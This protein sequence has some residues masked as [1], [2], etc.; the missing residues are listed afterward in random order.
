MSK[1]KINTII[2]LILNLFVVIS[3]IIIVALYFTPNSGEGNMN[4]SG[5]EC[6]KFFTIDSNILV[7]ITCLIV[8]IYDILILINKYDELPKYIIY[9]KHIGV[10]AITITFLVVLCYLGPV[11]GFDL[12]YGHKGVLTHLLNPLASIISYL[13]FEHSIKEKYRFT[14]L[15]ILSVLVYGSVYLTLVVFTKTWEDFY[16][17]NINNMWYISLI[18]II[19]VSYLIS[20]MLNALHNLIYNKLYIKSNVDN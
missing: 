20:L 13:F 4:V 14:F 3:T 6:F 17:F 10:T 7:A 18:V 2:S 5:V 8:S 19:I 1:Q 15:G 11:Q 9:I 16:S 12:M